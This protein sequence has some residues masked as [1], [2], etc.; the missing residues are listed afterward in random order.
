MGESLEFCP[1]I[2]WFVVPALTHT[3]LTNLSQAGAWGM[4]RNHSMTAFL[5][6]VPN[7]NMGG[8]QIFGLATVWAH[9]CQFHLTT[10]VEVAHKLP[11]LINDGPD[12]P[13]AFICQRST[14]QHVP[15]LD[16][17]HLGAMT[18]GI[19]S[20]NACGHLHQLQTWK[21]LNTGNMQYSP[22]D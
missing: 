5:T 20:I 2:K 3:Q 21:L 7:T 22:K 11:L 19:Q 6:I 17:G 1:R 4:Q 16:A 13:Y 14:T 9:P 12:W 10:L 18:D 15:L 8:K